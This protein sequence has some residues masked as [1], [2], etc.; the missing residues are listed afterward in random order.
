M[1]LVCTGQKVS[2]DHVIDGENYIPLADLALAYMSL[3]A[4]VCI[5]GLSFSGSSARAGS[6]DMLGRVSGV[7]VVAEVAMR[8]AFNSKI[9][10]KFL[11]ATLR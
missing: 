9:G 5:T 3:T 10:L 8:G 4:S 11:A 6:M 1:L 7:G 2:G